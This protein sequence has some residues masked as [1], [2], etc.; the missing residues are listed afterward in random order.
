MMS[1]IRD[2]EW[3]MTNQATLL[4]NGIEEYEERLFRVMP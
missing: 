4:F 3:G 2:V 1:H